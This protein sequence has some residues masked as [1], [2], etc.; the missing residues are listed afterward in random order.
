MLHIVYMVL[1]ELFGLGRQLFEHIA[2]HLL[3]PGVDILHP[4]V[5]FV[6]KFGQIEASPGIPEITQ[7][8]RL[9]LQYHLVYWRSTSARK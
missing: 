6:G 4:H 5:K 2:T 8:G 3:L 9:I 7:H 1:Q